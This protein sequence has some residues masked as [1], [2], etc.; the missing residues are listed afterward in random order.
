MALSVGGEALGPVKAQCS[1]VVECQ[2]SE[3]GVGGCRSILIEAGED[4][5]D[6]G[7]VE[8]KLVKGITL[9]I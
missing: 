7:F 4:R 1:S 3:V 8:E 6:R 9:E 5:W 2:G